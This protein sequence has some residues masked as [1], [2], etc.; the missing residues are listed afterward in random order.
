M[1]ALKRLAFGVGFLL[2]LFTFVLV[3]GNVLLYLLTG[4]LPSVEI[5]E[6]GTPVFGLVSPQEVVNMVKEQVEKDR[7]GRPRQQ[8]ESAEPAGEGSI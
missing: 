3:V 4:R 1:A 2:G 5:T 7:G 6:D 8:L